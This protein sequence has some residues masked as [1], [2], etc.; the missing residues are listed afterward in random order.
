MIA[1]T[2]PLAV[3]ACAALSSCRREEPSPAPAAPQLEPPRFE[4]WVAP[5]TSEIETHL[6]SLEP[7]LPSVALETPEKDLVASID[8]V[9]DGWDP[10]TDDK[11]NRLRRADLREWNTK[12]LHRMRARVLDE[13]TP[14]E[15]RFALVAKIAAFENTQAA[16]VLEEILRS[17][18]PPDLRARAAYHLSRAVGDWIVE[19][20]L[21]KFAPE[22]Q[23][24]A[25]FV[26][27][28][29]EKDEYVELWI[30]EGL[31]ARGLLSPLP[32]LLE[33][34][35]RAHA[36][37]PVDSIYAASALQ[38]DAERLL[39]QIC[40]RETAEFAAEAPREQ[41]RARGEELVA[42]WRAH[43][44]APISAANPPFVVDDASRLCARPC[45]RMLSFRTEKL[46]T[47]LRPVDEARRI[48]V[49]LGAASLP[50]L[51][52]GLRDPSLFVREYTLDAVIR[53]GAPCAPLV[54]EVLAL[55]GD[56][57]SRV[58]ALAAL[59]AIGTSS[60]PARWQ[61]L[62]LSADPETAQA[63]AE[64]LSGFAA[65]LAVPHLLEA[66]ARSADA[67]S[68][69]RLALAAALCVAAR[70]EGPALWSA[71]A[72]VAAATDPLWLAQILERSAAALERAT[73]ASWPREREA[74][75]QRAGELVT[76]R[77][78]S[79]AL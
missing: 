49:D 64:A 28:Y 39:R 7:T 58:K 73:G 33:L 51:R 26:P 4:R 74:F 59:G 24:G 79:G 30:A 60:E 36:G 65:P 71:S 61:G 35:Q 14:G 41:V 11:W 48:L 72:E 27:D 3:L 38:S 37:G 68:T 34:E 29:Y 44:R 23:N 47:P 31:C 69:L 15:L 21:S 19:A 20:L 53:L 13:Q 40:V 75:L 42:Y 32:Y 12:A 45:Q 43:G 22:F 50:M 77:G 2:L 10:A 25:F 9:V 52:R 17:E 18:A 57:L 16:H 63:A 5:S 55:L 6:R 46:S 67:P 78:A 8:E 54:P 56:P 1:R 70:L 76:A 66:A 62:V